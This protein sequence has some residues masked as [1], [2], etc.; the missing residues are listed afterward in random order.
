MESNTAKKIIELNR[1]FY[2]TFAQHF[3]AT[4][5]R[6]QPGVRRALKYLL[7]SQQI[8]DLGCGNGELWRTLKS[9]G[10]EGRYLGLDFS[11]R[12]LEFAAQDETNGILVSSPG[13]A[14]EILDGQSGI[15]VFLQADLSQEGWENQIP[16]KPFDTILAFAVMHHIPGI[17]LR[18]EICRKI[19]RLLKSGG[20]FW[21]SEWQFMNSAR[22]KSR[23]QPWSLASLSEDQVDAGDYLMDWRQGGVGLRYVHHFD[24]HELSKLAQESQ[25]EILETF[26][27]DGEGG[28]LGLYQAWQ[29]I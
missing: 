6:I 7:P 11:R 21:H 2:Q 29:A 28:H 14:Q 27:S 24:L 15:G 17:E 20:I 26:S 25:F 1:E 5:Q 16:G 13:Q 3:A 10:Y 9:M 4:R 19:H 22:L 18:L 8:L 12:L 23:I